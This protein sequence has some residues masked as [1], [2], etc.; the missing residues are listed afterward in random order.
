MLII[1]DW[2]GTL[3]DSLGQIVTA[4]RAAADEVGMAT[5]ARDA[6]H[7]IIGLSLPLAIE[8]LY[9]AEAEERRVRLAEAYSRHYIAGDQQPARLFSGALATLEG[10]RLRGYELAVATGKSR[11]GLERVLANLGLTGYFD[12]TRCADETRSKP[13][14][15]MLLEIMAERGRAAADV[16]MVGDSEYDLAMARAA[17]VARI[18]VSFGV[19]AAERL[20]RH[21]PLAIVDSLPELLQLESLGASGDVAS[22]DINAR[23]AQQTGQGDQW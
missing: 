19:H 11:R 14:P 18:G 9:P 20:A 7:D 2:D 1:F 6:V 10:L 22:K 15:A 12:S 13:D 8:A 16:L 3:C 23:L 21:A 5:P 17:G 4:M